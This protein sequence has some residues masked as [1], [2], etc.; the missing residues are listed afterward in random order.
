MGVLMD[1]YE[2]WEQNERRQQRRRE[3]M[4]VCM[5]CG[6]HIVRGKVYDI[7]GEYICRQCMIDY[8]EKDV[9]DCL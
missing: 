8:H 5:D 7:N 4:P 9:E 2:M 6:E 3:E 1:A